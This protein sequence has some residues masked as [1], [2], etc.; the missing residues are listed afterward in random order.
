MR[1]IPVVLGLLSALVV[2]ACDE[3]AHVH[4]GGVFSPAP[5]TTWQWQ[6]QGDVDTSVD[7][8]VYDVDLFD[9][10]ASVVD[11]LHAD[12]RKVL[13]YLSVG[14]FEPFRDDA[15]AFPD[16]VKGN[17]YDPPFEE[18]LY[19]D[20]RDPR[21][22][23]IMLARLDV[24]VDKGCDGVEPDNVDL[25]EQDTGFDI[26]PDENLAWNR[27]IASAAHERSLSVGLKNDLSQL[28]ELVDEYD[29]ALNEQCFELDECDAY[30]DT[31]LASGKAVFHAEY[32]DP[33]G[34]A[35]VCAVT[36]PLG[37]STIVKDLELGPEVTYCP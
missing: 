24:A 23:D 35:S 15:P 21:V 18:E 17:P 31:F 19:L 20:V 4:Q 30:A 26:T 27:F 7:V 1:Y 36:G 37:L 12:G 6:L 16:E 22:A 10:P 9:V 13:C 5:R 34:A 29:W 11:A 32:T 28:A 2:G 33:A 3:P 14:T 8:D 25:H